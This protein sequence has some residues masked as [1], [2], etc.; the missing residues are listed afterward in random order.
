MDEK[1]KLNAEEMFKDISEAYSVLSDDN[2]KAMFDAGHNVDGA[3]A[4][5]GQH[6]H[7]PFGGFGGHDMSD[8]FAQFGQQQQ[9]GNGFGGGHGGFHFGH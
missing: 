4:S 7:N 3:S 8:L 1:E 2:K 5:A 6:Q 9:G